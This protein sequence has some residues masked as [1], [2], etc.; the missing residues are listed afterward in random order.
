MLDI[1]KFFLVFNILSSKYKNIITT[2]IILPCPPPLPDYKE[3]KFSV[4]YCEW[5][6]KAQLHVHEVEVWVAEVGSY[7]FLRVLHG[8]YTDKIKTSLALDPY[9]VLENFWNFIINFSVNSDFCFSALFPLSHDKKNNNKKNVCDYDM[10]LE[11]LKL[12][13]HLFFMNIYIKTY[14]K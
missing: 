2:K 10:K 11:W 13:V 12:W 1:K 14:R 5:S 3:N 9:I 8:Y 6:R 7:Y 4:S